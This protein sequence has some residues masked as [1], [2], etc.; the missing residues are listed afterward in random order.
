M[1]QRPRRQRSLR[2]SSQ[3]C[4]RPGRKWTT[5]PWR[6]LRTW[7]LFP[8]TPA[9]STTAPPA[10]MARANQSHTSWRPLGTIVSL[11]VCVGGGCAG[12]WVGPVCEPSPPHHA[13]SP[14]SLCACLAGLLLPSA[15]CTG[16]ARPPPSR[17]TQHL[18]ALPPT[19]PCHA[20]D[21]NTAQPPTP[22]C[23]WRHG[24]LSGGTAGGP[25]MQE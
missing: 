25:F 1:C 11:Q 7:H 18:P 2:R 14:P 9:T 6:G 16:R 8:A 24:M 5:T 23:R 17:W 22:R 4:C 13:R 12:S 19:L 10:P 21:D 20:G 15:R 3:A